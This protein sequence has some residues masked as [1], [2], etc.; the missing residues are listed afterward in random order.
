M[1]DVPVGGKEGIELDRQPQVA[2]GIG[3]TRGLRF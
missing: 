3:R 1:R 2:Q